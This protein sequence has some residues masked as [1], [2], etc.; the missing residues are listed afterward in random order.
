MRSR[1]IFF[2][3]SGIQTLPALI[4]ALGIPS[5]GVCLCALN[6]GCHQMAA[7]QAAQS[8]VDAAQT[9]AQAASNVAQTTVQAAQTVLQGAE[10]IAMA[11][12]PTSVIAQVNQTLTGNNLNWGK[13][14]AIYSADQMYVF[15][16]PPATQAFGKPR[17][18]VLVIDA[19]GRT[20]RLQRLQEQGL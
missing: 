14:I 18:R 4:Y 2:I 9:T 1:L 6:S 12:V 5:L 20:A 10:Q 17:P 8:S 16:Y 7:A 15:V 13:P 3:R 19:L 11:A